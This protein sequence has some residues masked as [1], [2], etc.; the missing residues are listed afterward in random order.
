M[1]LPQ[2]HERRDRRVD[3]QMDV[4][5]ILRVLQ[6]VHH[7][8]AADAL[9][10]VQAR[11][12]IAAL[13]EVDD[14]IGRLV[15]HRLLRAE[16]DGAGRARL[17]AGRLETHRHAVGAQRA[18][19]DAMVDLRQPRHVERAAGD[20]VAAADAV[21]AVEVDDAVRVLDDRAGR[22]TRLQAARLLAV[23]AA[24]LADRPVEVAVARLRLE[25]AHD[26]PCVRLEVVR[27]VVR[28]GVGA[29]RVVEIVP[30]AARGLAGLAADALRDVDQLGDR[31]R[32]VA[33]LRRQR[34]GRG[35]RDDVLVAHRACLLM[36]SRC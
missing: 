14:T 31:N 18:L 25:V 4:L 13:V 33:R 27:V 16:H 11:V 1:P 26:G 15:D 32:L 19:V 9:R 23:H 35:T 28:A 30:L 24:V 17:D 7:V 29:E 36:P 3:R 10:V 22:R 5:R 20:A 8:R 34:R 12:R 6:H 2:R 21:V